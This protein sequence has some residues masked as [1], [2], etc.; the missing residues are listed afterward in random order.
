MIR[1]VA[2][3]CYHRRWLTLVVWLVAL[4]GA[5]FATSK[6]GGDFASDFSL[7]G[8]ESQKAFDLLRDRFPQ[9]SGDSAQLV[10]K[11]EAGVTD[12]EVQ[13]TM[14]GLFADIEQ[15]DHVEA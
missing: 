13:K 11:A 6:F 3:W 14:E 10:F 12:P 2:R 7:P 9:V 15:V 1:G 5:Q 8:A 4:V